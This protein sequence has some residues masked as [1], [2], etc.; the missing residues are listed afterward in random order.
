MDEGV[1]V[2]AE[3]PIRQRRDA[4]EDHDPV[5]VDEPVAEVHELAREEAVARENGR[6]AREPLV[7]RV[8]GEHE[9][10]ERE[11]LHGVVEDAAGDEDGKTPRAISET[12]E[13]LSLGRASIATAR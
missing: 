9:D 13:T 11:R 12:T 2:C 4:G 10:P 3:D 7:G 8:R 5:R 6:Q 1:H